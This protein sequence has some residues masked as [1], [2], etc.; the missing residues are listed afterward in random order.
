[1]SETYLN[2]VHGR[3]F[4]DPFVLKYCGEYWAYCSGFWHDGR[5][6]GVLHSRDLVHWDALAGALE[7]LPGRYPEYWAPEVV[8][9]N[10]RFL[11]YYSVGN[12]ERMQMRVAVAG[13][14]AG[15]FVDS[16]RRLTDEPFAIDG[17][18][19]VDDD[20]ARY[21]FY[22][23]DFLDR[24]RVGTGTVRDLMLDPYTLARQPRPVTLPCYDWQIYDPRRVEKGGVCWHT[25]EGPFVLKHKG[26]YYQMFSG[27]NWR[28]VSYG[29][30]YATS[31]NIA[32]PGEWSQACDGE[33]VLPVLRTLPGQ[34]I[35]P[36]HNSV[37]RGPDNRQLFCVY[38][39][40]AQDGS[41][42]LLA[43]DPLDWA[44]ERLL[45]LGPS[46]GP[47]PAPLRPAVA[48][49]FDERA[50]GLGPRWQCMGGRWSA[51]DGAA[52]QR[53]GDATAEARCLAGAACFVCEVSLRALD[54]PGEQGAFGA[55]LHDDGGPALRFMLVPGRGEAAVSWRDGA[56]WSEQRVALPA[57]FDPR[58]Y[59]LLRLE[60]DGPRV[61]VALDDVAARWEGR[62]DTQPLYAALLTW[63][64]AA[65]YA[66]FALTVGWQDPFTSQDAD[67]A[68]HGWQAEGAGW[69]VRDGRLWHARSREH[70]AIIKGP[71]LESYLLVVNARLGGEAE[72]GGYGFYPA[73]RGE[74]RGPLLA[75][76]RSGAGWAL[77]ERGVPGGHSFALPDGFDPCVD[78]Q[79]R[80]RKEG[81]RLA[82]QWE[83]HVLGT[84]DAPRAATRVGLYAHQA[85]AA[86]DMVRVTAI[87]EIRD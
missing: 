67:P 81:G 16:G 36:G 66:G 76:E 38:H 68:A 46:A 24:D 17:D 21:L 30:S 26:R 40:W 48:D 15:P 57:G 72:P 18:V 54:D 60:V 84:I 43:I 62:L 45:V 12:E 61:Y 53:S 50:D 42:R 55:A 29:V 47:Q 32:A 52:V 65:A 85:E 49:F 70:A 13:H 59:H 82:I 33:G 11:L 44:G 27:G 56:G 9:D 2:P 28:N 1:M 80:F 69:V 25:V 5:C 41:G 14:P 87:L 83:V 64:M 63:G 51:G 79:F 34:V 4:P 77:V 39:R 3:D 58:V 7:P 20:G 73:V 6:F 37:V 19:F 78:Q 8:Y 75:L 10:G 74:E 23:T 86:F 71:P 35:G 22:A 31:E